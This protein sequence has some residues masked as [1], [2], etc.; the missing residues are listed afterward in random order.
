MQ[1]AAGRSDTEAVIDERIRLPG[2]TIAAG[3]MR[4]AES[5]A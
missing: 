2:L 3:L 4:G 1:A 5:R